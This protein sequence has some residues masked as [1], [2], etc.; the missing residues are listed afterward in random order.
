MGSNYPKI[1]NISPGVL[2]NLWM[3]DMQTHCL[4]KK[5][6]ISLCLEADVQIRLFSL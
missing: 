6:T 5:S 4:H 1:L 2:F 3:Q